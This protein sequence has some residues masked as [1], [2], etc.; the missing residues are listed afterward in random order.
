V[1]RRNFQLRFAKR[2]K[3]E[4][5][6]KRKVKK[7]THPIVGICTTDVVPNTSQPMRNQHVE[8]Q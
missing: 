2:K 1:Q 3:S 7:I 6:K 4:R 5:D 8:A